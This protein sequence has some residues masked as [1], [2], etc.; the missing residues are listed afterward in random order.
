[1]QTAQ[2]PAEL[3][4]T[5]LS[6]H[7]LPGLCL[8]SVRVNRG[9]TACVLEGSLNHAAADIFKFN[10]LISRWKCEKRAARSKSD[11]R[12]TR[13]FHSDIAGGV[14]SCASGRNAFT[15]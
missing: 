1:M 15:H 12:R 4:A 9:G 8:P 6:S 7:S 11:T 14:T 10:T 3:T 13:N 5:G 2:K